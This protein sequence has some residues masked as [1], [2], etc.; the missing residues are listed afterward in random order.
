DQPI[1][2]TPV[3]VENP[4][5]PVCGIII[6]ADACAV[7]IER[8]GQVADR[9]VLVVCGSSEPVFCL[10]EPVELVVSIAG[11]FAVRVSQGSSI[12]DGIVCIT[13]HLTTGMGHGD[14]PVKVVVGISSSANGV[15]H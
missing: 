3:V 10:G 15:N 9:I 14:E 7:R 5:Q 8:L 4:S 12:P 13:D 11:N 6:E 1:T 2:A